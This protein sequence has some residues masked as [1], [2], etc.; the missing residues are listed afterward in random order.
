MPNHQRQPTPAALAS[1]A[2]C[3]SQAHQRSASNQCPHPKTKVRRRAPQAHGNAPAH[4]AGPTIYRENRAEMEPVMYPHVDGRRLCAWWCERRGCQ[5]C[6]R[7]I[8]K[9]N[10][11]FVVGGKPCSSHGGRFVPRCQAWER[12]R[13]CLS[14]GS[15]RMAQQQEST[16]RDVA[17]HLRQPVG[18]R[19]QH[20]P[21]PAHGQP[22]NSKRHQ[23]VTPAGSGCHW[24]NR[25]C[26]RL[27]C[28]VSSCVSK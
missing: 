9:E 3:N 4:R 8:N 11:V 24:S 2:H 10:G 17:V 18:G 20:V 13:V 27:S 19:A 23:G 25:V 22:I 12:S 5:R 16:C 15:S 7:A 26:H 6:S 14:W 1:N 28:L 21:E